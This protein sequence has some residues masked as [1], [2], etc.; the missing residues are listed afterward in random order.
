MV[1]DSLP[2]SPQP[3]LRRN[4][5]SKTLRRGLPDSCRPHWAP[6]MLNSRAT[7]GDEAGDNVGDVGGSARQLVGQSE[8]DA[9]AIVESR[10]Q[11]G[12][13]WQ[14]ALWPDPCPENFLCAV[15]GRVR[16]SQEATYHQSSVS[17]H[18]SEAGDVAMVH[19]GMLLPL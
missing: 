12:S 19:L 15:A 9:T 1:V 7:V 14:L 16:K 4:A 18:F 6:C 8:H 17:D 10:R 3:N 13:L 2:T 5:M 11:K